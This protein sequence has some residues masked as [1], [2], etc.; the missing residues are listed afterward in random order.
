MKPQNLIPVILL[1]IAFMFSGLSISAAG[2]RVKESQP[3]KT[4]YKDA[5]VPQTHTAGAP[6]T[7]NTKGSRPA[8]KQHKEEK[9]DHFP[10]EGQAKK[11]HS[12]ED[13]KH[14]HFHMHRAKRVKRFCNVLCFMAK[15][16]LLITHICLLVYVFKATLA[17]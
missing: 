9:K 8:N 11:A 5:A 2:K 3:V 17:H 15:I 10:K 7:S 6:V 13:G 1:L 4:Q 16:L 14:H 12:E